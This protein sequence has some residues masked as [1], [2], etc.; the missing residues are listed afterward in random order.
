MSS[1]ENLEASGV[2]PAWGKAITCVVTSFLCLLL[3]PQEGTDVSPL[4]LEAAEPAATDR[5]V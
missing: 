1:L 2:G 5:D 4:E 3:G